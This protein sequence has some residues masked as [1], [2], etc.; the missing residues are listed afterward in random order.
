MRRSTRLCHLALTAILVVPVG[1]CT[2]PSGPA[3]RHAG[4]APGSPSGSAGVPDATGAS[5]TAQGAGAGGHRSLHYV[6]NTRGDRLSAARLGYN[7][8]D[9][10][11]DKAAI[12]ALGPGQLALVWL[13]N[14]DNTN[15]TPGYSWSEFTA[16]VDRLAGDPKVYGYYL[17]DEPH[18][19]ICPDAAADI[20]QRADYIRS[21]DPKQ[22]SFIVVIGLSNGCAQESYCEYAKLKPAITHVDLIGV[23]VFLCNN[24]SGCLLGKIDTRVSKAVAQGVPLASIVPVWQ[25]FGQVCN[26]EQS[27]Y[28]VLPSAQQM[29]D[30]LDRWKRL[31]PDPAFDFT[32]TWQSGGPACPALDAANGTGGTS[33]LQ[34]LLRAHNES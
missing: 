32:Y 12:D 21:R 10:G 24:K 6:S 20:R 7:L 2:A 27:H 3:N 9:I 4:V 30:Q 18:P 28:Y 5:A 22:K 8:F 31:V 11:P 14:L 1:G 17:A 23:N 34:S 25:A 19:H 26:T 33:D 13:G 16:A 29:R 15:C